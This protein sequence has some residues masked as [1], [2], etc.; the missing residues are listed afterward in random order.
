MRE[1]S[2]RYG[3]RFGPGSAAAID[4]EALA[5][6]SADLRASIARRLRVVWIKPWSNTRKGLDAA[7]FDAVRRVL[8]SGLAVAT[9][10]AHSRTLVGYRDDEK[11]PGGGVFLTLDSGIGRH[12]EVSYEFV[13][14]ELFD[15]FWFEVLPEPK[16]VPPAPT[17]TDTGQPRADRD[18]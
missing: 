14:T 9:G 16:P 11:Q 10:M 4:E 17:K 6:E 2:F 8:S 3:R 12:A 7:Q 18:G 13:R 15:V 1:T 5:T